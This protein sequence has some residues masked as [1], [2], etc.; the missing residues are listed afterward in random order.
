[1][2][3]GIVFYLLG[4]RLFRSVLFKVGRPTGHVAC[5]LA[6]PPSPDSRSCVPFP[7]PAPPQPEMSDVSV[8]VM[9]GSGPKELP[10]DKS[11]QVRRITKAIGETFRAR[12][13]RGGAMLGPCAASWPKRARISAGAVGC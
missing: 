10:S 12:R 8:G 5:T 9:G 3:S 4:A 7:P 13:D 2:L 6:Q 11:E 1:M